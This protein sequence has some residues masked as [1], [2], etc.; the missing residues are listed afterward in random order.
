[1]R[2]FSPSMAGSPPSLGVVERLVFFLRGLLCVLMVPILGGEM[3]LSCRSSEAPTGA[4][5]RGGS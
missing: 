1:M 2:T 5:C 3:R 4:T